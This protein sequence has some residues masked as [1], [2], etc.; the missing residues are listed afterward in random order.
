MLLTYK[1]K[2]DLVIKLIKQGVPQK[3]IG[4]LINSLLLFTASLSWG[5]YVLFNYK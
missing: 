4:I 5:I 1:E 3:E 2:K